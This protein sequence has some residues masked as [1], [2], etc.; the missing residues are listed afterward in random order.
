MEDQ[1]T[2]M[3]TNIDDADAI[4]MLSEVPLGGVGEHLRLANANFF[5]NI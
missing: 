2:T 5:S 4:D 3:A 1:G